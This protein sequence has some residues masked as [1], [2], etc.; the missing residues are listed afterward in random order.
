LRYQPSDETIM[1][2]SSQEQAVLTLVQEAVHFGLSPVEAHPR[3]VSRY[4]LAFRLDKQR[5]AY[6]YTFLD[7]PSILRHADGTL[8]SLFCDGFVLVARAGVTRGEALARAR[9]PVERVRGKVLG[10]VLNQV[11]N[12]VPVSRRRYLIE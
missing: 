2:V 1:S 7:A 11:R 8:R 10:V 9:Q 6:D 12:P 5:A 4:R 3:S